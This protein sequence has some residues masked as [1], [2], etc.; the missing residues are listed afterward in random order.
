MNQLTNQQVF[1]RVAAHLLKQGRA[2]INNDGLCRYRALDGEQCAFG[3][4]IPDELYDPI[5]EGRPA[6]HLLQEK[7]FREQLGLINVDTRLID[8]LQLAHDRTLRRY[9][10]KEWREHM[11]GIAVIWSLSDEILDT[12]SL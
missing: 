8:K 5:I 11:R 9:S 1:N 6:T 12:K 4:I 7:L 10:I 2:A 3:C